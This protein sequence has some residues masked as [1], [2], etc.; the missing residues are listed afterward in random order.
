MRFGHVEDAGSKPPRL[1]E[2][3]SGQGWILSDVV[4]EA[5]PRN[6]PFEEQH[7]LTSVTIVVSGSFQYRSS[8]GSEMMTPGSL[9]L[10]NAGDCFC[11]G[12]E[13]GIGDRC[14]S[15]AYTPEFLERVVE[16]GS[17]GRPGFPVPRIPPIRSAASLVARGSAFLAGNRSVSGE[18]LSAQVAAEATEI[19]LQFQSRVSRRV[20][21]EPAPVPVDCLEAPNQALDPG[22]APSTTVL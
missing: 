7:L 18:E 15:F 6:R 13:Y 11:C 9:L 10:G 21:N 3:A 12:H 8:T 5:G 1:S 14:T 19:A 2:L 16:I 20:R 22:R 17:S 4:C